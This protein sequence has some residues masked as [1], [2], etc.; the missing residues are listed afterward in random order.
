MCA[1]LM[2]AVGSTRTRAERYLVSNSMHKSRTKLYL[3]RDKTSVGMGRLEGTERERER[4]RAR[5]RCIG[6]KVK[7]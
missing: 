5:H 3:V 7:Q 1:A 2:G 6:K 4:S